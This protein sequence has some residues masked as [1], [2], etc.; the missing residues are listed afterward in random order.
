MNTVS[1]DQIVRPVSADAP[2]GEDLS[3]LTEYYVLEDLVAGA[4]QGEG[5]EAAAEAQWP[6]VVDAAADLLQRGKELRVAIHLAHALLRLQGFRGLRDGLRIV[7]RLL[8]D[9]WDGLYPAL[10]PD[11][12]NPAIARMNLLRELCSGAAGRE[13]LAGQMS[14]ESAFVKAV[15]GTP[16]CN[17]RRLGSFTWRDVQRASG[18]L[19]PAEGAAAPEMALID[20]AI[21][22]TDPEAMA[23][24][25]EA[26]EE[27]CAAI[28][29]MDR[30]LNEKLGGGNTS[31]IADLGVLLGQI[32]NRLRTALSAAAAPAPATAPGAAGVPPQPAGSAPPAGPGLGPITSA[33]DVIRVL[34]AICAWYE[35]H[36]KSSPVP[37]LLKRAKRLVGQDFMTIVRDVA[38]TAEDQVKELFGTREENA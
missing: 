5:S 25:V 15:R 24:Q 4:L 10:D 22:E 26:L 34:D 13:S 11:E 8:T 20:G 17:S 2:C 30:F 29:S 9:F 33:E 16:L 36:E 19:P 1:I 32:R 7:E 38:R 23:A 6:Q 12:D 27:A 14:G 3:E 18:E 28:A 37:Y 35:A 31:R 21:R